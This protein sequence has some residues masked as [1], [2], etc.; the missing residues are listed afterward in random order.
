MSELRDVST[1][2][3]DFGPDEDEISVHH[4]VNLDD[5]D[6]AELYA[7]YLDVGARLPSKHLRD[8]SIEQEL[9]TQ[10][11]QAQAL[12]G[13]VLKSN[14]IP[15]NQLSQVL[16]TVSS[17]LGA[18]AKLQK[19]VYTSERLKRLESLLLQALRT[20]PIEAQTTFLTEY[21]RLLQEGNA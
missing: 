7:L 8:I 17:S 12:Q 6:E 21:E 5:L 20:M 9:V 13:R 16:N 18:L 15:A 2:R 1:T 3:D 10:Y 4:E 14:A 11:K 19:E